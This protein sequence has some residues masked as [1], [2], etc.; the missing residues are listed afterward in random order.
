MSLEAGGLLICREYCICIMSLLR[1]RFLPRKQWELFKLEV[2]IVANFLRYQERNACVPSENSENLVK[3]LQV[4][5]ILLER[6]NQ[7]SSVALMQQWSQGLWMGWKRKVNERNTRICGGNPCL[8][9]NSRI[10]ILLSIVPPENRVNRLWLLVWWQVR[11]IFLGRN[12]E[13]Q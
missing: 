10:L 7:K 1:R 9:S 11:Q 5:W 4:W 2:L 6:L 8:E 12:G 3:M 13:T